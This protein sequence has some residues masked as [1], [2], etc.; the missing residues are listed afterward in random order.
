MTDFLCNL[1]TR[2][3][4]PTATIQPRL[5][6]LFEPIHTANAQVF[7][8]PIGT[9]Q[10]GL[11]AAS[12][13][14]EPGALALAQ[15]STSTSF[16]PAS[17]LPSRTDWQSP[18][19]VPRQPPAD[20]T[21][22]GPY[23][24]QLSGQPPEPAKPV[25]IHQTK[26]TPK[27]PPIRPSLNLAPPASHPTLASVLQPEVAGLSVKSTPRGPKPESPT[28]TL[29]TTRNETDATSSRRAVVGERRPALEPVLERSVIER[30]SLRD[31][32]QEPAPPRPVSVLVQE[33]SPSRQASV[34]AQPQ[35]T[36][37]R[38]PAASAF[39]EPAVT[40]EPTPSVQVTIGRVEVRA[41]PPPTPSPK[42]RRPKPPVM[43]LDEY[44][45]Q[46]ANGG[47]R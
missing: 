16:R 9:D 8:Y 26:A 3:L 2:S 6:S 25:I 43:S 1:A 46:R 31:E 34:V 23:H 14:V 36:P 41:T 12:A 32:A 24:G 44:L 13:H 29:S 42:A 45:R 39:V 37:Y 27:P 11:D 15:P 10:A 38:E 7:S 19:N 17:E 21:T 4:D 18:A 22:S 47:N 28:S 30:V 35:V 33:K 5:P 20:L 40:P